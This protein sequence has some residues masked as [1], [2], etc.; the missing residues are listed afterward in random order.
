ML[1][2]ALLALLLGALHPLATALAAPPG[3]FAITQ[4]YPLCYPAASVTIR[5]GSLASGPGKS[6]VVEASWTDGSSTFA[7]PPITIDPSLYANSQ[8][9][10]TVIVEWTPQQGGTDVSP[11]TATLD[12]TL[13]W[14]MGNGNLKQVATA[15]ASRSC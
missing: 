7:F 1:A 5:V 14:V 4:G 15:T 13:S 9:S 11:F 2:S 6:N 12:A 3:A 8:P 10:D